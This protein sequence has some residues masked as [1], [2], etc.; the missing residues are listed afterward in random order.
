MHTLTRCSH[1]DN[2]PVWGFIGAA[3]PNP[4]QAAVTDCLYAA[5]ANSG[6]ARGR[7]APWPSNDIL[8]R[9][10]ALRLVWARTPVATRLGLGRAHPRRHACCNL[11]TP[12]TGSDY[13]LRSQARHGCKALETAAPARFASRPPMHVRPRRTTGSL[14]M[15]RLRIDMLV[16]FGLVLNDPIAAAFVYGRP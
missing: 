5:L 10:F 4:I 3:F 16:V 1:N 7:W 9:H 15:S 12:P 8:M 13:G 14:V 2:Q 6:D 11:A